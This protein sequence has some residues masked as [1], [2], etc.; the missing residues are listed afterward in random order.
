MVVLQYH[1][2]DCVGTCKPFYF[3]F[4]QDGALALKHVGN[5]YVMYDL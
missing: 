1:Q 2:D 5:L 4:P 3:G